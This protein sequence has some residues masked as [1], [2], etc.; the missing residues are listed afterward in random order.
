MPTEEIREKINALE[1]QLSDLKNLLNEGEDIGES[2]KYERR[3]LIIERIK[4]KNGVM[5]K[6]EWKRT[7]QELN[8]DPQG[9]NGFFVGKKPTLVTLYNDQIGLTENGAQKIKHWRSKLE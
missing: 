7:L 6:E 5:T 8:I 4:D 9:A 3:I 1:S 2:G